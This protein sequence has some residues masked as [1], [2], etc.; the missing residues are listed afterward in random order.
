MPGALPLPTLL[1]RDTQQEQDFIL[2]KEEKDY[3]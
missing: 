3:L 1:I 2:V